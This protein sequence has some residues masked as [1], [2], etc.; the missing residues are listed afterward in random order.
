MD[1]WIDTNTGTWGVLDG[2]VILDMESLTPEQQEI[3]VEDSSDTEIN[4][5]GLKAGK[6][7]LPML[8]SSGFGDL[9]FSN[10]VSY[11]PHSLRA[12]ASDMREL[13][14]ATEDIEMLEWVTNSATTEQLQQMG[15]YALSGDDGWNEYYSN[16][17]DAMRWGYKEFQ[18][19]STKVPAE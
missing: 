5:L 19:S 10:C 17:L 3:L 8:Q 1:I 15:D 6:K 18:E 13:F 9:T 7:L 2:M 12:E 11:S 16:S 4:A 14:P